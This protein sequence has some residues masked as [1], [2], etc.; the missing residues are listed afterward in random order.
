MLTLALD[1][2]LWHLCTQTWS[3]L[4]Q[5]EPRGRIVRFVQWG[6]QFQEGP[7]F[8]P[9]ITTL[10]TTGAPALPTLPLKSNHHL[11][12]GFCDGKK[13]KMVTTDTPVTASEINLQGQGPK[14]CDPGHLSRPR[15]GSFANEDLWKGIRPTGKGTLLEAT[16]CVLHC[17]RQGCEPPV[18]AKALYPQLPGVFRLCW[19]QTNV[20]PPTSRTLGRGI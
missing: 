16:D 20:Y 10:Q 19:S 15:F 17:A 2:A 9:L 4:R 14:A 18:D 6:C 7:A 1:C 12:D 3:K 11:R 13:N 5:G 8:R